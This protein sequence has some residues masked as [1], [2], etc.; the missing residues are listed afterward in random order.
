LFVYLFAFETA[1]VVNYVDQFT[2]EVSTDVS[3]EWSYTF[4]FCWR[5]ETKWNQ[6]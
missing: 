4:C 6:M 3:H 1:A 2:R 5:K